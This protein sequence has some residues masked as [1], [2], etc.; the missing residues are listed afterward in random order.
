[1]DDEIKIAINFHK[2]GELDKAESLYLNI[3]KKKDD[4]GIYNLLGT[5]YLQKKKYELSKKYLEKSLSID[6]KNPATLN[7]LGIVQKKILNYD[8]AVKFF[9]INIKKN[10]SLDSWIN[11]SN[12]LLENKKFKEG[13]IFSETALKNYPRNIKIRN[14]YAI[15][16][17]NSGYKNE[18]LNIYNEFDK[19]RSHSTDTLINYS[20]ILFQIKAYKKALIIINQLLFVEKKNLQ[21]IILRH[22]IYKSMS[23]YT[24]AEEDILYA[25][26][27]DKLNLLTNKILI[28]FYIH[29]NEYEKVILHCDLM[30]N[31]K[32]EIDFFSTKKIFSKIYLG[33]WKG[34]VNE[35]ITFNQSLNY[36]NLSIS[37]LFLKYL[38]DDPLLQKK[39]TENYCNNRVKDKNLFQ[40]LSDKKKD[41]KNYKIKIGYFSGDF[42]NH[43]VFQLIQDLFLNHDKSN[44]EIYA[45]S[46]LKKEGPSRNKVKKYVDH[47]FDI[48]D[49]S[50]EDII[51]L[52]KLHSLDIAIDLSGH[53][54][55]SNSDLFEFDI[56]KIKINYLGFPGTMGTTKYDFILADRFI[57]PSEDIN[58]YSESVIYL[59]ENYQPYSPIQFDLDIKRSDFD[60][61]DNVFIL[62]C[63]SRIEKIL[64]NIF[65][66]WMNILKKY[67]DSYLALCINNSNVKNNIKIYCEDN[68][69]DF[70]R[71]IFL[72]PIKHIDNLKRMSTFNLYLDTYPYNG[73]TGISDSLFQSCVPTISFTGNSF[74]SRVSFSLLNTLNLKQLITFNEKEYFDKIDY[75]CSNRNELKEIK[76][77]LTDYKSKNLKRMK[78]FTKDFENLMLSLIYK[79][80]QF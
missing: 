15:F 47:F 20:N 45:Y 69:F 63:F 21:G 66:I 11:K 29:I 38:N 64:P 19:E 67:K 60:L 39:L 2:N 30:I 34:L 18:S 36:D 6:A 10:N 73:H 25:L 74:A 57:I 13:L 4:S 59:P 53:T 52:V 68:K 22:Q 1:M 48:N 27:M 50:D 42:R 9:E 32:I 8:E 71:I 33:M 44:F 72:N 41:E 75:F 28:E 40:I 35:L 12:I 61:P 77:Y 49:Q 24:K 79:K 16:L 80:N 5:I 3:L 78:G 26:S 70:D 37:P 31:A 54:A 7:N 17:F 76:N 56:A 65:D 43:A 62:G 55:Y 58:Y 51:G 23:A 14:N 46:S